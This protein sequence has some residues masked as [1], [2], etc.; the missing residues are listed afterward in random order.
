MNTVLG[1]T[2]K[3][4]CLQSKFYIANN[5]NAQ[6]IGYYIISSVSNND[7]KQWFIKYLFNYLNQMINPPFFKYTTLSA[8]YLT[9]TRDPG[10]PTG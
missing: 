1:V 3:P 2:G 9:Q 7:E 5:G 6:L 4:A 8:C 10:A